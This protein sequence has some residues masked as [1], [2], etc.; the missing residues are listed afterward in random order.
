MGIDALIAMIK[1]V[2]DAG[3]PVVTMARTVN[4]DLT[5]SAAQQGD[6]RGGGALRLSRN[7]S[8]HDH[9]Q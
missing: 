8:G 5:M 4:P 1:P 9:A 6:G 2:M 3:T 7:G